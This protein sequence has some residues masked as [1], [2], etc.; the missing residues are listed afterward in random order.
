MYVK[1][2]LYLLCVC[3][4][5][6]ARGGQRTTF[7]ISSFLL[8]CEF[9]DSESPF[10]LSGKFPYPLN[11]HHTGPDPIIRSLDQDLMGSERWLSD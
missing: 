11:R 2:L 1:F 4:C 5:V 9:K 8:R 6:Y 10:R 3:A 7:G